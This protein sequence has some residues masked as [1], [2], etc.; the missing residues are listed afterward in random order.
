MESLEDRILGECI[1]SNPTFAWL[2]Q[3]TFAAPK[4]VLL[5]QDASC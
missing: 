1:S 5:T 3:R 2:F 4:R